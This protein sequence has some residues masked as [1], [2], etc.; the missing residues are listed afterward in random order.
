MSHPKLPQLTKLDA[1]KASDFSKRAVAV[2]NAT[3]DWDTLKSELK[4]ALTI[5]ENPDGTKDGRVEG[6]A[7][8]RRLYE[9]TRPSA[10]LSVDLGGEINAAVPMATMRDREGRERIVPARNAARAAAKLGMHE[11]PFWGRPSLRRD[12]SGVW[13]RRRPDGSWGPDN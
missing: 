4:G 2:K 12:E 10:N 8:L 11:K 6:K 3:P 7:A 5:T 13:W 1:E 9:L